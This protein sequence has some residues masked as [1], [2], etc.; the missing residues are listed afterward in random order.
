MSLHKPMSETEMKLFKEAVIREYK[1]RKGPNYKE[2]IVDIFLNRFKSLII[3]N[4]AIGVTA[5]VFLVKLKGWDSLI[6]LLL[7]GIVWI[8][9]ISTFA[10]AI[11]RRNLRYP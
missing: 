1:L 6:H 10:G 2:R 7:S 9:L 4:I 5:A 8:T 11:L 3:L